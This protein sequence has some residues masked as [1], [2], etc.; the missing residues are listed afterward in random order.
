MA[1]PHKDECDV[2]SDVAG[3]FPYE[4]IGHMNRAM[5]DINAEAFSLAMLSP[6][7]ILRRALDDGR[8]V[9]EI[10]V[11]AMR[12]HELDE[13]EP[14]NRFEA[15]IDAVIYLHG[16]PVPDVKAARRLVAEQS[17]ACGWSCMLYKSRF[18]CFKKEPFVPGFLVIEYGMCEHN[19]EVVIELQA[20]AMSVCKS[21]S[22]QVHRLKHPLRKDHVDSLRGLQVLARSKEFT[23]Q[24][25]DPAAVYSLNAF[26]QCHM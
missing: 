6:N 5:R 15:F 19:G 18:I 26:L 11:Q 25:V 10:V 3:M 17:D 1:L 13:Y 24:F 22:I 4:S 16:R 21:Y 20:L 23:E 9:V 7:G 14:T 2:I 8:R 12:R